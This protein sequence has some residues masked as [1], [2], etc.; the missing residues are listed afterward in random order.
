MSYLD[1]P[2]DYDNYAQQNRPANARRMPPRERPQPRQGRRDL[3]VV[4]SDVDTAP[5]SFDPLD[6]QKASSA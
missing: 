6:E 1:L 2:S 3:P 5:D 4:Q